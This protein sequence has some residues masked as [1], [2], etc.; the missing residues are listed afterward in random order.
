[1]R[2]PVI[3]P[4]WSN[5][6]VDAQ[7]RWR[8]DDQA[9]IGTHCY[10]LVRLAYDEIGIEL[11]DYGPAR[12]HDRIRLVD[13]A[14]AGPW[15]AVSNAVSNPIERRPFD[16]VVFDRGGFD[17]HCGLVVEPRL[18]L[19]L[20]RSVG[21]ARCDPIDMGWGPVAGVYRHEALS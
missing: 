2:R 10:G 13:G 9:W 6:Y 11:E 7:I 1:M 3:H 15:T 19:H 21:V 12:D 14:E 18:M 5:R 17:D 20:A 8:R 16:V 4:A